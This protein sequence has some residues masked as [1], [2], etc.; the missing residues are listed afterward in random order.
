MVPWR[1]HY[2]N[3]LDSPYSSI[4]QCDGC[5]L[6]H[7]PP[8]FCLLIEKI[9]NLSY[10]RQGN[11]RDVR[12]ST[13]CTWGKLIRH[14]SK[15]VGFSLCEHIHKGNIKN[16]QKIYKQVAHAKMYFKKYEE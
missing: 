9:K 10:Y 14:L 15:Y 4:I 11:N 5:C 8:S 12:Y 6:A 16:S 7:L 2:A 13:V 1:Y 3:S